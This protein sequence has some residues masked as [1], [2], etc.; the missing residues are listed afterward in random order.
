MSEARRRSL[1][2][3]SDAADF[4][5]QDPEEEKEQRRRLG[6]YQIGVD[7]DGSG[8][9]AGTRK[10]TLEGWHCEHRFAD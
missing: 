4:G 9:V 5:L 2:L 1:D 8:A 6:S 3:F 7:A 10:V